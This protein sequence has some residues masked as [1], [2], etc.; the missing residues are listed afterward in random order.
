MNTIFKFFEPGFTSFIKNKASFVG[1]AIISVEGGKNGP[2][3]SLFLS[4]KLS[5]YNC[6]Y[7]V[8]GSQNR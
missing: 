6:R 5:S 3:M 1:A 2:L 4:L 7:Y 8:M